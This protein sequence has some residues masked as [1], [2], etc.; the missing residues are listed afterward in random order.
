MRVDRRAPWSRR[1]TRA[2]STR[3]C[4]PSGARRSS[5]RTKSRRRCASGWTPSRRS[6]RR[7]GTGLR[8]RRGGGDRV[9]RCEGAGGESSARARRTEL[10]RAPRDR[11]DGALVAAVRVDD[12]PLPGRHLLPHEHLPVVRAR[13][14]QRAVL[15]VRP[16]H[17]P[18][19]TTCRRAGTASGAL[20]LHQCSAV[21]CG[22]IARWKAG[23]PRTV[24]GQVGHLLPLAAVEHVVDLDG[25]ARLKAGWRRAARRGHTEPARRGACAR[26]S[27]EQ[28][29]SRLP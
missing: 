4:T 24:A 21:L 25:P 28:V 22:G 20:R 12:R 18:H 5:P 16:H 15:R 11:V 10:R 13:G 29:A 26:R 23:W 19:G 9:T 3:R 2:P 6:R 7:R 17:L 27:E 14:E 8:A 1:A